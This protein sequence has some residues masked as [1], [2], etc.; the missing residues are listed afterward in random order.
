MNSKES[1]TKS[2]S[3]RNH[4]AY[5]AYH[6]YQIIR[7][8]NFM[9]NS[10]L[11][12]FSSVWAKLDVLKKHLIMFDWLVWI[13][14]DLLIMNFNIRLETF[15]PRNMD[16]DLVITADESG[17][18]AGLFLWRNSPSGHNLLNRWARMMT[19][20]TH[21]QKQLAMLIASEA[22]IRRRTRVLPL[23]AFNSRLT[24]NQLTTRFEYGDF[25]VHFAGNAWA[26]HEYIRTDYGW[27][28]F[29]HFSDLAGENGV[30]LNKW[31]AW[32]NVIKMWQLPWRP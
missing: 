2:F 15:L 14:S 30:T 24:D 9:K 4:A 8:D 21:E 32:R 3:K 13:D 6:A 17:I 5:A 7:E 11:G 28:L 29:A 10:T 25:A 27:N 16:I 31:L 26:L 18:N 20:N 1:V 22:S 19:S 12:K 23:C